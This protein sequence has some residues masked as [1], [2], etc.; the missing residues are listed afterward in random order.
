MHGHT[1]RFRMGKRAKVAG[2]LLHISSLRGEG[3]KVMHTKRRMHSLLNKIMHEML[4][5]NL[6][7]SLIMS[8]SC[9]GKCQAL[10]AYASS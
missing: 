3:V 9:E 1:Q 2:I 5:K 4:P 7:P 6:D 8:C 10:L